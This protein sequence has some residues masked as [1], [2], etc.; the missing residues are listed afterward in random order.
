MGTKLALLALE[1]VEEEEGEGDAGGGLAGERYNTA[2]LR[3]GAPHIWG[4]GAGI[5]LGLEGAA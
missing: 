3:P 1:I 5:T 2:H 4:C